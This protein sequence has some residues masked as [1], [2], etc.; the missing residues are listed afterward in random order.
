MSREKNSRSLINLM[1]TR[2]CVFF[3]SE[4][5]MSER[6]RGDRERGR[7]RGEHWEYLFFT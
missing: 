7:E 1:A 6:E 3:V 2:L 4:R 5:W